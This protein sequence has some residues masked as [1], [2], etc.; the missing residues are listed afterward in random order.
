MQQNVFMKPAKF[1]FVQPAVWNH[2]GKASVS[3][4]QTFLFN[5]A[6]YW[7]GQSWPMRGLQSA[8]LTNERRVKSFWQ[9]YGVSLDN[10]QWRGPAPS[11]TQTHFPHDQVI[12]S[13]LNC[14]R[15]SD[16]SEAQTAGYQP[17]R[18]QEI[19]HLWSQTGL[20]MTCEMFTAEW[21]GTA[22]RGCCRFCSEISL[23]HLR[24]CSADGRIIVQ[25]LRV[26]IA[27]EIL[28]AV[29]IINSMRLSKWRFDPPVCFCQ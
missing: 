9:L 25:M 6:L 8:K 28:A 12:L 10:K 1:R 23:C 21:A 4:R 14:P 15:N 17:I 5:L 29:A 22:C 11:Q 16:Q 18:G 7:T 19:W 20:E 3:V 26:K 24:R 13:S 2:L 27:L